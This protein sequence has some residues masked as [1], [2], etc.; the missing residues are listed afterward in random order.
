MHFQEKK[1]AGCRERNSTA[2]GAEVPPEIGGGGGEEERDGAEIQTDLQTSSQ[3]TPEFPG[4]G[5]GDGSQED[6]DLVEKYE[7]GHHRP[8]EGGELTADPTWFSP[9]RKLQY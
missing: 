7:T 1:E 9:I 2:G 6:P 4:V 8:G 5:E 3:Q